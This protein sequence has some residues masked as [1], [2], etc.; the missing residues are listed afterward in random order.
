MI[1]YIP[2]QKV[3]RRLKREVF[4][5]NWDNRWNFHSSNIWILSNNWFVVKGQA[6]GRPS[7]S[8]EVIREWVA[9]N[10]ILVFAHRFLGS[11]RGKHFNSLEGNV[12]RKVVPTSKKTI[13]ERDYRFFAAL[14]SEIDLGNAYTREAQVIVWKTMKY[15]VK[16]TN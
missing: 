4:G 5:Y 14:L 7:S 3:P 12:Y 10:R 9:N 16:S 11:P 6:T 13:L 15:V 8:C 1:N 2:S